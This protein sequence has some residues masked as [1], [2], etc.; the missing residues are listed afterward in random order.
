MHQDDVRRDAISL[1]VIPILQGSLAHPHFGVRHAACQCARAL[2]RSVQV[3][4]TSVVDSGISSVIFDLVKDP[5]EDRRVRTAALAALC[6]LL[7]SFSPFREVCRLE[8][9]TDMPTAQ[10]I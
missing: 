5:A 4:R 6:N 1:S 8:S 9:S 3:L 7:N 2:T 10:I